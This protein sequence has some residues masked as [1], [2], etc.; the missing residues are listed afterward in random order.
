MSLPATRANMSM[1][2][3][4]EELAQGLAHGQTPARRVGGSGV[5]ETFDTHRRE[6]RARGGAP[7]RSTRMAARRA[8][9][10]G[11]DIDPH[12]GPGSD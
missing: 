1:L 3:V 8:D 12:P 2:D 5:K 6:L 10:G 11:D 4:V 9:E 7:G